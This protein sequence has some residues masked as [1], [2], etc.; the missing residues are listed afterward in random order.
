MD[1]INSYVGFAIKSNKVVYGADN[2]L[3][4]K[5]IKLI[6]TSDELSQN[7]MEKLQNTKICLLC[8]PSEQ[9]NSLNLKGLAV[10]IQDKSLADAII[11]LF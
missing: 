6:L 2:I 7:T 3:K 10:G 1:K 8:L 9:Y 11:K 4:N 5:K